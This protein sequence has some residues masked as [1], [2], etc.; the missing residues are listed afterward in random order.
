MP[1][2]GKFP[3]AINLLLAA[4]S[5]ITPRPRPSPSL[6]HCL[7]VPLSPSPAPFPVCL[8]QFLL[9]PVACLLLSLF[10]G[11]A[12]YSAYVIQYLHYSLQSGG[13]WRVADELTG[14]L[15][16]RLGSMGMAHYDAVFILRH[17]GFVFVFVLAFA[18]VI[19]LFGFYL[20]FCMSV[21]FC[22]FPSLFFEWN[23]KDKY[24]IELVQQALSRQCKATSS[25]QRPTVPV[26]LNIVFDSSTGSLRSETHLAERSAQAQ[27]FLC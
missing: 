3:K 22:C 26:D 24:L 5:T 18:F 11:K 16:K 23:Y 2:S 7:Q 21:F 6:S 13:C 20:R 14:C 1:S 9:S 27:Q 12:L 10:W 15:P 17:P 25:R 19:R 4:Q 8:F